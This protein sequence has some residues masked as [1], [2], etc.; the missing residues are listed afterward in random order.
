MI[1]F[2]EYTAP[3][4]R[5][6]YKP[7]ACDVGNVHVALEVKGSKELI[8]EASKLGWKAANPQ[9][10]QEMRRTDGSLWSMIYLFSPDGVTV[11]LMEKLE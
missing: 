4:S 11:E 10:P 8:E 7:R 1:E 2:L 5:K 3:Q 6:H 9:G